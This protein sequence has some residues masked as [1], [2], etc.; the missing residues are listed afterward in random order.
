MKKFE[1][2]DPEE[3]R[4]MKTMLSEK[5]AENSAGDGDIANKVNWMYQQDKPNNEEYLLGRRLDKH[6]EQPQPE[7]DTSLWEP[8]DL[9]FLRATTTSE[10][11]RECPLT[12]CPIVYT[13][14]LCHIHFKPFYL[15]YIIRNK[16]IH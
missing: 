3:R 8:R 16:Y 13:I 4:R 12:A 14:N 10:G 11:A 15:P 2:M 6:V 1:S 5:S 9:A 7:V